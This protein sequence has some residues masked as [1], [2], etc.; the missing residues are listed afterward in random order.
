M[1]GELRKGIWQLVD[2]Y[3]MERSSSRMDDMDQ[4]MPHVSFILDAGEWGP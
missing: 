2:V 1:E 3:K 4:E